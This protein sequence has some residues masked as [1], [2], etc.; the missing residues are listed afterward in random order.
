MESWHSDVTQR[1][2]SPGSKGKA[3]QKE[4]IWHESAY[5]K[6]KAKQ[7]SYMVLEVRKD[8]RDVR[9]CDQKEARECFVSA[10][11]FLFIDLGSCFMERVCQFVQIHL[12]AQLQIPVMMDEVYVC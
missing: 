11:N 9:I 7:K 10:G 4:C 8:L 12:A 3:R 1:S 2:A 6:A 5:I